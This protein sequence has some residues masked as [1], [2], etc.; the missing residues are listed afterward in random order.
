MQI[1]PFSHAVGDHQTNHVLSYGTWTPLPQL[2]L[3]NN[4]QAKE[5]PQTS[6]KK[7]DYHD[8][9]RVSDSTPPSIVVATEASTPTSPPSTIHWPRSPMPSSK[10]EASKGEY[11]TKTSPT[12]DLSRSKGFSRSCSDDRNRVGGVRQQCSNASR[13]V[14]DGHSHRHHG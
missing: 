4:I 14:N 9:C 11:N 12:S 2:R 13:K 5:I 10:E 3:H 1:F 8:Q 7:D 6:R